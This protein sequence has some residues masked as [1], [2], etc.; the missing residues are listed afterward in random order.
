[1]IPRL[2]HFIY[3]G[4]RPFSFV[5][6]LAIY[7]AWKVN[8]PEC[9]YFHHTEEPVGEW[10]DLA[11]PLLKLN[12]VAPVTEVFGNPVTYPAH[13]ADVIRL[14]M[15]R[16]HGGIYLDLDVICV[17][18]FD[19]LMGRHCVMGIEPG[20]GLCN[21]VILARP[22][23]LFIGRWQ[24]EYRSF[25]GGR[26]NHHSVVL[27]GQMAAAHPELID[28]ANKY[29][30]FYPTHNDPVCAYLWGR[31]P[32]WLALTLRMGKNL[33]K[34]AE[35]WVRRNHDPIRL[36][37]YGTFHGLRGRDW[38]YR[39]VRQSFC[40]HLWEGLWGE[41]YLKEL[42]PDYLKTSSASFAR[43]MREILTPAE[44][45]SIAQRRLAP[46]VSA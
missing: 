1:M 17:N 26:W 4:G 21:A 6:F 33:L 7:T 9:I 19:P 40:I 39:R 12:R 27:P 42:S 20:T 38:H 8:R 35:L 15:L 41:R 22:D 43:L 14:E 30:F 37:F 16:V 36:A 45:N 28:L 29:D 11:R 2:I 46:P 31:R 13:Q 10:W 25:D 32:S 18:P 5:H 3:V 44:I 23:A 24:A 34:L